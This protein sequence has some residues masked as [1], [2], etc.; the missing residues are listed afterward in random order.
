MERSF[1]FEHFV[2]TKNTDRF[3]FFRPERYLT[4]AFGADR[5]KLLAH[6]DPYADRIFSFRR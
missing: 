1:P 4:A 3:L 5:D 2:I 6:I